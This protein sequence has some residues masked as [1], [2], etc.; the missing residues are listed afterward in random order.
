[1]E[2]FYQA[3]HLLCAKNCATYR[4]ALWW[5][6]QTT[7]LDNNSDVEVHRAIRTQ[8]WGWK[9]GIYSARKSE[10]LSQMEKLYLNWNFESDKRAFKWKKV[11]VTKDSGE[12]TRYS[13]TTQKSGIAKT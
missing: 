6:N 4:L 7:H 5:D 10:T 3:F 8:S 12:T 2:F 13:E 11:I 9:S 1:M